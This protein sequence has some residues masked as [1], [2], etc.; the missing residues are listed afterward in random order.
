MLY[1]FGL[2]SLHRVLPAGLAVLA[3]ISVQSSD[4]Q[5]ELTIQPRDPSFD[6]IEL[7]WP[8]QVGKEYQVRKSED[9][10]AG[11]GNVSSGLQATPPQNVWWADREE[12][13]LNLFQLVT[14]VETPD[15]P[16]LLQNGDFSNGLTGWN[17]FINAAVSASLDVV[18]GELVAGI[19]NGG[20][21]GQIQLIQPGFQL[22]NGR[23]YSLQFDARS[24]PS[25]RTLQVRFT[26]TNSGAAR[27]T[28][29]ANN[30]V[31]I[32]P[33]TTRYTV[34]FTMNDPTD[35]YAR[36]VFNLGGDNNDVVLDNVVLQENAP[37]AQRAASFEMVR[38]LGTGNNFMAAKAI[39][40]HGAPED[41]TLLNSHH[42]SHCRIGYKM[43][44]KA[45]AGP[46]YTLPTLDL[47]R[48]Q[49]L[50][51]SCLAEGLI[52]IVDPV[53]NWANGPGYTDPADVPKLQK[54]WEQ[55]ASHFAGYPLDRVVFEIMNEPNNGDNITNIITTGLA[56]IRT[57][58]GNEQRQVIVSGEGFSTR[59]ALINAFNDDEIPTDDPNLIGTF[60]YYDPRPFTK[61]G[62]PSGPLTNINWGSS[63]DIGDVDA[64]FDEVVAANSAWATR[65][66]T[67]PLPIYMGEFGV[68]N[69]A[70]EADRKRWLARIR[71]AA[72]NHGFAA[73]HWNMY[74]NS[75]SAKGM[76]PWGSTYIN[77]PGLRSFDAAPAEALITR[78][79]AEE[80]TLSGGVV[81]SADQPGFS[82]SGYAAYPPAT[83]ANIYCEVNG[84][85]PTDGG[86]IVE[87]HYAAAFATTLTLTTLNNTAATVDSQ[88]VLFPATGGANSWATLEVPLTF[89]AGEDARLRILA[90]LNPGPAIDHVRFTY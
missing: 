28:Y 8:S 52:A 41:Y 86:Y 31:A 34:T 20:S 87:I 23:S 12:V 74:Q 60:H 81:S 30:A 62:D 50:V 24:I 14:T 78:Y 83:G 5:Q 58:P 21:A 75:D 3:L 53:H 13:G 71:M 59:Q 18:N 43:D 2:T 55:V 82:G 25:A 80:A 37:V 15:S 10:N 33:S 47:Q 38:R 22:G 46:S 44:E 66:S 84:Y 63:A 90:D 4:A 45:G 6:Q 19:A 29:F 68:D 16:N 49:D 17:Q 48:L 65:N 85:I 69:F 54:I 7:R 77:N 56:A 39:Q 57:V 36:V 42:F 9:L 88:A 72:E 1:C 40:G 26:S 27:V 61:Q 79:E 35:S 32:T 11:F 73:A 51:D 89:E 64:A 67:E 76:G 70:L